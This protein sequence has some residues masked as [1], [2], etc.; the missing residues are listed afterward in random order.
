MSARSV[1]KPLARSHTSLYIIGYTL[2][3]NPMNAVNVG[4]LSARNLLSFVIREFMLNRNHF[5]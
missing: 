5:N 4:K 2:E 3:K 1:E